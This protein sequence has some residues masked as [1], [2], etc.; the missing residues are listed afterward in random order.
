M[1]NKLTYSILVVL[2]LL[3]LQSFAQIEDSNE[4]KITDI[5]TPPTFPGC[6]TISDIDQKRKCTN[7]IL[8]NFVI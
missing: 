8:Q 5:Y 4:Q 2:L 6:I 1:T 3:T 7:N